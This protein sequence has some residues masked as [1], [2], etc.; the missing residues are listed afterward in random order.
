MSPVR[1]A[2]DYEAPVKACYSSWSRTYYDE[3]YGAGAPYPP[4]HRD[5]LLSLL[6]KAKVK[7]LLDAGCGPASFLRHVD[8]KRIEVYGFDLTPEM[9]DEARRVLTGRKVPADRIWQGSVLS[10][11]AFRVP[12]QKSGKGS[13]APKTF[14]A[15]TCAGVFPHIPPDADTTVIRNLRGALPKNGLVIVEARNLLFSLFTLNRPSF[16]FFRDELIR[17]TDLQ[18]KAGA[19]STALSEAVEEMQDRFRIDLPPLRGGKAGA[20]GYD[21]VLSRAHNPLV[22]RGQFEKLGFK[23]VRLFFYHFH[24]L[25]PMSQRFVP[26]LFRAESIA[27]EDPADWR[28]HFMASAFLLSAR[29]A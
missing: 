24:A 17:F 26:D 27:M 29:R 5:L 2:R 21:E 23:D 9:V 14:E 18:T 13:K 12:G 4:V 6:R 19:A 1:D 10:P 8:T 15:I 3:Y 16:E 22:L 25:P 20:P 7:T 28:G 11:R